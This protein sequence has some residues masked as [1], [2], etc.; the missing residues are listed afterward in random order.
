M[1]RQQD[2]VRGR[3]PRAELDLH[4]EVRTPGMVEV[5]TGGACDAAPALADAV[6]VVGEAADRHGIGLEFLNAALAARA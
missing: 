6:Q 3:D 4:P 2:L 5:R 1:R